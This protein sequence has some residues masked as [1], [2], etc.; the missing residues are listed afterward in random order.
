MIFGFL[1][2]RLMECLFNGKTTLKTLL[3][4]NVLTKYIKSFGSI[5]ER[6][7]REHLYKDHWLKTV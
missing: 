7:G 3:F 1:L 6:K 2:F 5:G 4:L